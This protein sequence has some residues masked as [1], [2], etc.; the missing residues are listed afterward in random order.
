MET[1][2]F[3]IHQHHDWQARELDQNLLVPSWNLKLGVQGSQEK[4]ENLFNE[5]PK[6][7]KER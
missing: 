6:K 1:L 2:A 3:T 4:L 5:R 7:L